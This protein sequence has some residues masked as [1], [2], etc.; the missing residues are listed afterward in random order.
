[1][2]FLHPQLSPAGGLKISLEETGPPGWCHILTPHWFTAAAVSTLYSLR[3]KKKGQK[4]RTEDVTFTGTQGKSQ[5]IS[6]FDEL[7]P[8]ADSSGNV[9]EKYCWQL[10]E[11]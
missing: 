4:L 5:W 9:K 8:V 11:L 6:P 2:P 7:I 1:M 3:L 10:W